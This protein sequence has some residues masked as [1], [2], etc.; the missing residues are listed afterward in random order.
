MAA[1]QRGSKILLALSWL[2]TCCLLLG[3]QRTGKLLSH[4]FWFGG[5]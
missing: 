3:M 4:I 5:F 1:S 2:R